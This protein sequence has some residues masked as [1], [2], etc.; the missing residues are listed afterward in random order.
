[1][2]NFIIR[3]IINIFA[4]LVVV[5][6]VGGTS[7]TQWGTLIAA[8]LVI[9]ILNAVIKPILLILTLPV[10]ILTLGLFT[11]VINAF[12]LYLTSEL[13]KGFY[14]AGFWSAFWGAAVFSIVSIILNLF[15]GT[16]N[17][18]IKVY[19]KRK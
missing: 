4:L 11:L 1:M 12:L 10:N 6:V 7:I 5:N 8:A 17:A 13:V 14:V 18:E 16:N 3:I 19:G 15:I 2:K 9:A